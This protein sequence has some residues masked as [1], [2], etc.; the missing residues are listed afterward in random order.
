[1]TTITAI[2]E[3]KDTKLKFNVTSIQCHQAANLLNRNY[4]LTRQNILGDGLKLCRRAK[5]HHSLNSKLPPDK[6]TAKIAVRVK[7]GKITSSMAD[8]AYCGNAHLCPYCSSLKAAH[9]RKWINVL[10]VGA[11]DE[12]PGLTLGLLTLTASHRRDCDWTDWVDRYCSALETFGK[13]MRRTYDA[14]G[15]FG[16]AR[17][18]ESPVGSNGLHFH[19]HELFTY[20]AGTDIAG[21]KAVI[22]EAWKA[23]LKKHGLRCG[24]KYGVDI[25]EPGEFDPDYIAKEIAAHDTKTKSKSDL[26]T[27]FQLL[28]D[29]ARGRKE[30]GDDWIRAAKALQG[31][32]RWNVGLLAKKLSIQCPSEWRHP[33]GDADKE[34]EIEAEH[35][36]EY[37][38]TQHMMATQ[39]GSKRPG[40]AMIL[41]TARQKLDNSI[42][43]VKMVD[44][45]CKDY[46][47]QVLFSVDDEIAEAIRHEE[48]NHKKE[49]ANIERLLSTCLISKEIADS[50]KALS[51]IEH[52]LHKKE[53]TAAIRTRADTIKIAGLYLTPK[54]DLVFM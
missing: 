47:K 43:T 11:V 26:K 45:L 54:A 7:G 32:D 23:A 1:M 12:E 30:S 38:Q 18:F 42:N 27:L 10:L 40:L 51:I 31:R 4:R 3:K 22:I 8:V 14:I 46:T 6:Q 52:E 17:T 20:L 33:D 48:L 5:A 28:D 15:S 49:K 50:L 37:P 2:P 35:V 24:K 25:K 29:S 19:T 53:Q 39:P 21:L 9:M 41:R 44:A 34:K 36:I 16:R 13:L